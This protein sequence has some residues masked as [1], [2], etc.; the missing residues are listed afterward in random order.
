[1]DKSIVLEQIFAAFLVGKFPANEIALLAAT[2]TEKDVAWLMERVAALTDPS[3]YFK[4][5]AKGD[6]QAVSGFFLFID[7]VSAL[8]IHAGETAK[9]EVT[10][11]TKGTYVQWVKKY[12]LDSRFHDGLLKQFHLD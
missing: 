4:G 1:M 6:E 3:D 10:H 5:T 12:V 2:I 8:I 7:L 11:Y 9:Q